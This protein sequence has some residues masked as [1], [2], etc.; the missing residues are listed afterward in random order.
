M[1]NIHIYIYT[2]QEALTLYMSEL[3]LKSVESANSGQYTCSTEV[4]S[5]VKA[6][7]STNIEIG[8]YIINA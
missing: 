5:G 8:T 1:L 6:S 4:V 7:A 2:L 3:V